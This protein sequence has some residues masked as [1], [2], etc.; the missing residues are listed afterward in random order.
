MPAKIEG[1]S[2]RQRD[3][4]KFIIKFRGSR[5]YMPSQEEMAWGL[6]IVSPTAIR[7]HL[8]GLEA[9]GYIVRG[10]GARDIYLTEKA[11]GEAG[12]NG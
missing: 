3:L 9:K 6:C 11:L 5:G 1:I 10:G 8:A 4:L 12:G 7:K 2:P